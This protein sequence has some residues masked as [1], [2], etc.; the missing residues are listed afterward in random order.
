MESMFNE[1]W[2]GSLLVALIGA[3]TAGVIARIR[4]G[5]FIRLP[6]LRGGVLLAVGLL[7]GVWGF[8]L[9]PASTQA[10]GIAWAMRG[11]FLALVLLFSGGFLFPRERP[12]AAASTRPDEP[13]KPRYRM[14]E[15]R[16]P[17]APAA[18]AGY[19]QKPRCVRVLPLDEDPLS[20]DSF[21]YGAHIL[22]GQIEDDSWRPDIV[23]SIA[24]GGPAVAGLITNVPQVSGGDRDKSAQQGLAL[25]TG[26]EGK[27]KLLPENLALPLV[28]NS[29]TCKIL[30]VDMQMKCGESLQVTMDRLEDLGFSSADV[31]VA[32]LT[33]ANLR[34]IPEDATQLDPEVFRQRGD[35]KPRETYA[36]WCARIHY[37]AFLTTQSPGPPWSPWKARR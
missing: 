9:L 37:L 30:L 15:L 35:R 10:S 26:P 1:N 27:R 16:M 5:L 23:V 14:M 24:R 25:V 36:P 3:I 29:T 18:D 12:V 21:I 7:V 34:D 6:R 17:F 4:W 8:R 11:A 31:R 22:Y 19:S 13:V 2:W 20:W 28:E 32:T 33:L